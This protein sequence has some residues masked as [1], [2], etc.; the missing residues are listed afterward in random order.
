MPFILPKIHYFFSTAGIKNSNYPAVNDAN[1][2]F[3]PTKIPVT[4]FNLP[5][6][7]AGMNST[8]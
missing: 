5:A 4:G 1:Q 6:G 7:Q 3:K 8:G 2:G